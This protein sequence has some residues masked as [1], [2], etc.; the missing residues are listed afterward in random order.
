MLPPVTS[1]RPSA[2]SEW[3]P[4][5]MSTCCGAESNSPVC[6]FH[7]LG[8]PEWPQVMTRPSGSR[9]VWIETTCQDSTS[10]QAPSSGWSTCDGSGGAGTAPVGGGG[11]GGC[12][13]GSP[14]SG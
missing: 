7:R 3:P 11:G 4:Q 13:V 6:G 5:K 8:S 12:V 1:R 10:D 2:S 9:C 14:P